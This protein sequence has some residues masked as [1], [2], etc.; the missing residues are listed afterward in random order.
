MRALERIPLPRR[1]V[2]VMYDLENVPMN[3]VTTAL[4]IPL[5]TG[6]S[7]L[8]TARTELETAL[9]RVSED[10]G[11][12]LFPF[13][14]AFQVVSMH[15]RKLKQEVFKIPDGGPDPAEMLQAK[16]ARAMV[17]RALESIPLSRREVLVMYDLESVP[18]NKVAATLSIPLFTAY[19]RLRKAR[20]ELARA[21]RRISEEG[22]RP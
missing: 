12:P 3:Q 17:I 8:R 13:G 9:C 7:R 22:N 4:S 14:P 16:Q 21:V 10:G 6:Y 2:L 11:R 15:R 1:E 19:S 18:M 20:T 5:F